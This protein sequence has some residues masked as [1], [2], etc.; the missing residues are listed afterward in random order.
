MEYTLADKAEIREVLIMMIWLGTGQKGNTIDCGSWRKKTR[1]TNASKENYISVY[2]VYMKFIVSTVVTA[3][4]TYALGLYF[5]WWSL[6]IAA[7][8]VAF[9]VPQ[10][11][12]WA[13]VSAF[14]A[15]LMLWGLMAWLISI[16]NGHILAHRISVLIVKNDSPAMLVL[17]TALLGALPAASAGLAGSMLRKILHR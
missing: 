16:S 14:V 15:L 7:F 2:S 12:I 17:L 3:L 11:P 8:T 10:K 13:M 9:F 1:L 5:P 4:L 6:A